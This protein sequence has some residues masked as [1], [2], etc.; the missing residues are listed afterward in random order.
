MNKAD[1]KK[2]LGVL[3]NMTYYDTPHLTQKEALIQCSW[4]AAFA[5]FY[6]FPERN[7]ILKLFLLWSAEKKFTPV[8]ISVT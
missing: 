7:K 8:K 5:V 6:D 3:A 2:E 1:T 4:I